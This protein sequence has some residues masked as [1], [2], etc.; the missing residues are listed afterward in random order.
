M[1]W[2][3]DLAEQAEEVVGGRPCDLVGGDATGRRQHLG[4]L[5]DESGLVALAAVRDRGEVGRVGLDQDTVGRQALRDGAQFVRCLERKDAGEGDGEA[6]RDGALRE[7]AA[8][9]EA[10]QHGGEGALPH[11]LL[12]DPRHVGVRVARMDDERQP[13]RPRRRDVSAEAPLLRIA[14][15]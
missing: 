2:D 15:A 13:G 12:E 10:V 8:A 7:V 3:W 6:E 1:T 9:G 11:F 4:G 14:R 5:G